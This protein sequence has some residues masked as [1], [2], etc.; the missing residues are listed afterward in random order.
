M[1]SCAKSIRNDL[2]KGKIIFSEE[3]SLAIYEMGNMELIELKQTSA[4]IQCSSCLKH[5]P[6]GLNVCQCGVWPRPKS[7]YDRTN[8]NSFCS[9]ENSLLPY[10]S[11]HFKR[12]EKWSQTMADRSC[13]SHGCT[14]RS[15]EEQP[16]IHLYTGPMAERSR[17]TEL[18]NWCTVGLRNTSSTSTTSPRLTSVMMHPTT[19]EIVMRIRSS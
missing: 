11:S 5:I 8:Q 9:V 2:S 15:N 3:S 16:Q 6:E 17:S 1:G 18:L 4:T 7:K 10:F 14:K 19:S 13:Q 12:K